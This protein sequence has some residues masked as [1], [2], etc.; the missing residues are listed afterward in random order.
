MLQELA[1][2]WWEL[3]ITKREVQQEAQQEQ[4]ATIDVKVST[5]ENTVVSNDLVKK[6]TSEVITTLNKQVANVRSNIR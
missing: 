1:D 2:I 3:G 6:L 5:D 4:R